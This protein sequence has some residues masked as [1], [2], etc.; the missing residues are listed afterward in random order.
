MTSQFNGSENLPPT[1]LAETQESTHSLNK[2]DFSTPNCSHEPKES[3]FEFGVTSKTDTRDTLLHQAI[4][5]VLPLQVTS[6]QHLDRLL[7]HVKEDIQR[8]G[9]IS[10]WNMPKV[11]QLLNIYC[12]CC[13][14]LLYNLI[15]F[16]YFSSKL[17]SDKHI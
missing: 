15:T 13:L 3:S 4:R 14:N 10:D 6:L 12:M 17:L 11:Q 2:T 9:R 5:K 8:N 16:R 7:E 1:A